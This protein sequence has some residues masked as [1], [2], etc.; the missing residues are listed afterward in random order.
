M[1]KES[2]LLIAPLKKRQLYNI[3][4]SLVDLLR[5]TGPTIRLSRFNTSL[6]SPRIR[7]A[8]NPN[9][10]TRLIVLNGPTTS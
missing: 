8:L 5:C 10:L 1:K 6:I 4:E 2:L 3:K 9:F 7:S